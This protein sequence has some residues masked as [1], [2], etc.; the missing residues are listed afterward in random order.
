[1]ENRQSLI[2]SFWQ[3]L[4]EK[5]RMEVNHLL[6]QMGM[7]KSM[8]AKLNDE[9]SRKLVLGLVT[10]LDDAALQAIVPLARS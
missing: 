4:R 5:P 1:V 10:R 2:D 3:E 8:Y 6:S 7:A 9:D